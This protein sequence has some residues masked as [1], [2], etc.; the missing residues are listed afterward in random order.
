[1]N[2]KVQDLVCQACGKEFAFTQADVAYFEKRGWPMPPATCRGCRTASKRQPEAHEPREVQPQ[3]ATG[4][5]NE[6]RSPMDCSFPT[7]P[8]IAAPRR[9]RPADVADE[10]AEDD[11]W[12]RDPNAVGDPNEYRSP[13]QAGDPM[14]APGG[15]RKLGHRFER[16]NDARAHAYRRQVVGDTSEYRSPMGGDS[17]V[18]GGPRAR[19]NGGEAGTDNAR[20]GRRERP[21][22]MFDAV[23]AK[24]GAAAQVPFEPAPGRDVFCRNCF[25]ARKESAGG[26]ASERDD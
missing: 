4:D 11:L 2:D 15:R 24:C 10:Q 18:R 1:M 20:R 22:A 8:R 13:M 21:R 19:A 9:T 3:Y 23:C 6:Y 12:A 26:K 7:A 17:V 16:G 5:P 25:D 14:R